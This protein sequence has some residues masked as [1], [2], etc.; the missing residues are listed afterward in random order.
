M[1]KFEVLAPPSSP[2]S[3]ISG[4]D[5]LSLRDRARRKAASP[6]KKPPPNQG[7]WLTAPSLERWPLATDLTPPERAQGPQKEAALSL[8]SPS[9]LNTPLPRATP[10]W[11][12]LLFARPLPA[13]PRPPCL[14]DAPDAARSSKPRNLKGPQGRSR[15]FSPFFDLGGV[16]LSLMRRTS[17]DFPHRRPIL[18]LRRGTRRPE[19]LA[20]GA[21]DALSYNGKGSSS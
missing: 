14:Q 18:E 16:L 15:D 21:P 19:P 8:A 17:F 4:S 13:R 2:G 11:E 12:V 9:S 7:F 5:A 20:A 3:D 10:A 6:A 1:R